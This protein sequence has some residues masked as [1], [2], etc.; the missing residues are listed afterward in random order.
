MPGRNYVKPQCHL[1]KQDAGYHTV[2]RTEWENATDH[3]P[4]KAHGFVMPL[5]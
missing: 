5:K 2:V 1:C 4:V 3:K